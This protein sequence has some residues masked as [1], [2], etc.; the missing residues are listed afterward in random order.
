MPPA[1]PAQLVLDLEAV[2]SPPRFGT[3]LRATDG[4]RS[5][6]M[7]LYCWN[8]DLSA[9]FYVL[10][11]FCEIG[12]RNGA[13]EAVAAEFGANWHLNRG[14][15]RSSAAPRGR[16]EATS[17]PTTSLSRPGGNRHRA[18]SWPS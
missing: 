3:Y 14:F 1:F 15:Y 9:A 12:T 18:R 4:D 11:Q 5:R 13:V 10:L 2:L 6:A 17:P 7:D 8:T 16:S